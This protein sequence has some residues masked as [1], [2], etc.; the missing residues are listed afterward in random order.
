M[1]QYDFTMQDDVVHMVNRTFRSGQ[2]SPGAYDGRLEP[3]AWE[4]A[5]AVAPGWDVRELE[6]RWRRWMHRNG[7][8]LAHPTQSFLSF[9]RE[10]YEKN[11]RP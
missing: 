3:E 11:G 6:G 5:R 1:P 7:Q 8:S 9:C 2:D 10:H 4:G